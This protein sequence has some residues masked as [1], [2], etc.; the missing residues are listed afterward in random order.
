MIMNN[1]NI[2]KVEHPTAA[3]VVNSTGFGQANAACATV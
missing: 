3:L 1:S 2:R